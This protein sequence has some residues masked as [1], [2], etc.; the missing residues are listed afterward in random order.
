MQGAGKARG[1]MDDAMDNTVM[2]GFNKPI[3]DLLN[4]NDKQNEAIRMSSL[5]FN[6]EDGSDIKL[7]FMES[8]ISYLTEDKTTKNIGLARSM[9]AMTSSNSTIS[10]STADSL[11]MKIASVKKVWETSMPAVLEHN[12]GQDDG[13]SFPGSFASDPNSLDPSGAFTKG[14]DTPEDGN[15]GYSPSPNQPS[16][17]STSNVCKVYIAISSCRRQ[18][19]SQVVLTKLSIKCNILS[20]E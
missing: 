19:L 17:N 7:D 3:S 1:K 5:G 10:P 11:N 6:K 13:S 14:N 12:V 15:E 8:D 18:K 16:N 4:K 20:I 9:H 2:S